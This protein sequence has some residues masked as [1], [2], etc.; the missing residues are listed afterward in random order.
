LA[1]HTRL[2]YLGM[3]RNNDVSMFIVFNFVNCTCSIKQ[4]LYLP[5]EKKTISKRI[6]DYIDIHI[7]KSTS[8]SFCAKPKD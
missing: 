5:S 3:N 1:E 4:E 6:E 2:M 8:E 7:I